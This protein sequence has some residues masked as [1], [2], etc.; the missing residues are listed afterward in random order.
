ML[1]TILEKL[2][3]KRKKLKFQLSPN[4]TLNNFPKNIL[5]LVTKHTN[6]LHEEAIFK[7]TKISI[8]IIH[9]KKPLKFYKRAVIYQNKYK[10]TKTESLYY[11]LI[12]NYPS[13]TYKYHCLI[14]IG[15]KRRERKQKMPIINYNLMSCPC[16][17]STA[18]PQCSEPQ[19]R[20][21]GLWGWHRGDGK[22]KQKWQLPGSPRY[23]YNFWTHS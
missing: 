23:S 20:L 22:R 5:K 19:P 13:N 18:G 2:R 4:L 16:P 9:I 8:I 12:G 6:L 11:C 17:W 3:V 15:L 10:C 14:N 7:Y 1:I 21:S